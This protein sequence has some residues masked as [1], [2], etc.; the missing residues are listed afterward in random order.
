LFG[1]RLCF[2]TIDLLGAVCTGHASDTSNTKGNFK[3][4][5][6]HFMKNMDT[7]Y[8]SE[9]IE[10]LQGIFRHKLVH[11]VQPKV[12]LE[13]KGRYIAWKYEYPDKSNYL[14]IE[15]RQRSEIKNKLTP[16][17]LYYDHHF[18]IS[19]TKL[20]YDIIDS[21]IRQPDGYLT[22]L[23]SNHKN[24]QSKFDNAIHQA[25]DPEATI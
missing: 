15:P 18:T 14:K 13:D 8:S 25:Y 17:T 6:I 11:L 24:L 5:A 12:V 1:K 2:S 3:E 20:T 22:K 23:K 7:E 9:Q 10:L 16:R 4:S 21:V 19:I